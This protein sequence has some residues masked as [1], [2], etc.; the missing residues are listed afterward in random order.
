MA[1]LVVGGLVGGSSTS[2]SK[3]PTIASAAK[4]VSQTANS[5][6]LNVLG[7]DAAGAS[8]LTYTWTV[9]GTDASSVTFSANGTNAAQT[10]T[11]TFAGAGSYTFLV[12]VT[13]P[14]GLTVTSQVS[15]AVTQKLTSVSVTPGSVTVAPG[16]TQQFSASGLDQFGNAMATQPAFT[17]SLS[18]TSAGSISSTGLFTAGSSAT[19]SVVVKAVTGSLSS[20]ATVTFGSAS[21][22][23][24][25]DNFA[26]GAGNWTVTDGY[27]DFYLVNANGSNR[28]L[29]ENNG[30]VSRVVAGSSSWTN[31]SYQATLNVN[32]RT[33]GSVSLLARVQDNTHL[34]FFGY[35]VA[36]GEWMIALRD[37]STVTILATSAPYHLVFGQD[38]TVKANLS[39]SSLS[40]YVGGVLEVS[41][42]DSTYSSGKIG[43]TATDGIGELGNVVVTSITSAQVKSQATSSTGA[44]NS[45]GWW[46]TYYGVWQS[47]YASMGSY[48]TFD[49]HAKL[50]Q[51]LLFPVGLLRRLILCCN[52]L[53]CR[54]AF[55]VPSAPGGGTKGM[56]E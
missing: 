30:D 27:R 44:S 56:K 47:Y 7:A 36:L 16:G 8:S 24:F 20:T 45:T 23:L 11:A 32:S 49:G 15:V 51:R 55:L 48:Y 31:Y 12:T 17:W 19:G 29:V 41:A 46:Q 22:V 3:P 18:S 14:S 2:P 6:T 4:V 40:L 39:G 1:N 38:Y 21:T 5:A 33:S 25:Q 9:T 13:D 34:Y 10:T 35:N 52:R 54:A 37:G 50:A 42:T 26:N 43:F 28:I 53:D